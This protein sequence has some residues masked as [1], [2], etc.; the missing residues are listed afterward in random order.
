MD[1]GAGFRAHASNPPC[2]AASRVPG[3]ATRTGILSR[4]QHDLSARRTSPVR[5]AQTSAYCRTGEQEDSFISME[6]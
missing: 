1:V 5:S 3:L 4:D 2:G 6:E